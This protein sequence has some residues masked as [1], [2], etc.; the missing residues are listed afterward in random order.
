M[1]YALEFTDPAREDFQRL[2]LWLQEETLDELDLLAANPPARRTRVGDL[3][4]DFVRRQGDAT[5][6]VFVTVW[7]D[8]ANRL[9]RVKAIGVYVRP[10]N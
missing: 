1:S 3:V 5:V 9:L 10:G 7:P 6:Y 4:H 8:I 2:D